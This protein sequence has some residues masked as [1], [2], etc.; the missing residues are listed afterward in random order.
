MSILA[1]VGSIVMTVFGLTLT[2]SGLLN[3]VGCGDRV[4]DKYKVSNYF[5]VM[6]GL[7]IILTTI[8]LI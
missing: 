2:I 4:G 3:L 8:I 1:V 6:L 7:G 5:Q